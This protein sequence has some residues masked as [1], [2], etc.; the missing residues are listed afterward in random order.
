MDHVSVTATMLHNKQLQKLNDIQQSLIF[1]HVCVGQISGS[2]DLGPA[3]LNAASLP[4]IPKKNGS[5]LTKRVI[6][7]VILTVSYVKDKES[8]FI[9]VA[10][11]KIINCTAGRGGSHL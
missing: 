4:Q 2:A 5:F 11:N 6:I 3:Q 1:A 10:A 9:S 8:T 7:V